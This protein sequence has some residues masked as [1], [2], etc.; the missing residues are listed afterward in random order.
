M[1]KTDKTDPPWVKALSGNEGVTYYARHNHSRGPCD[2]PKDR[3]TITDRWGETRCSWEINWHREY[4][5]ACGCR[6]CTGY[7]ER[8]IERRRSRKNARRV[9]RTKQFDRL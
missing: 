3:K 5:S 4:L 2:L 7:E 6:M 9:L 8:K 1:S